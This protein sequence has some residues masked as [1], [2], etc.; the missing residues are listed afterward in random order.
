[1]A[2]AFVFRHTHV[3]FFAGDYLSD[4]LHHELSCDKIVIIAESPAAAVASEEQAATQRHFRT[5]Q[6]SASISFFFKN[7]FV[8]KLSSG[9]EIETCT[10]PTASSE[11]AC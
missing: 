4:V 11:A 7:S 8:T 10:W 6:Q 3:D 5:R 1:M 2:L 9:K